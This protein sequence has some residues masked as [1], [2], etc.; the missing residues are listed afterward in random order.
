MA[1]GE[2]LEEEAVIQ[3]EEVVIQEE[4]AVIPEEE[5][6]ETLVPPMTNSRDNNLR[7]LTAIG[8]SRKP[9]CKNGR[10]IGASIDSP[11]K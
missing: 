3:E 5:A 11:H 4:E 6:E 7:S 9:S 1:A 2:I 8:G 10:S